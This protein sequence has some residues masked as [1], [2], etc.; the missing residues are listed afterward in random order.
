MEENNFQPQPSVSVVENMMPPQPVRQGGKKSGKWIPVVILLLIAIGVVGWFLLK[1][2][3]E[4]ASTPTPT[5]FVEET[6]P[7]ETVA[8]SPSVSPA[9]DK[10]DV[11]VEILNGT[12]IAGEAALLQKELKALGYTNLSVGNSSQQD[13][14][15]TKVTFSSNL[16]ESVVSEVTAKLKEM[17]KSVDVK[18]TTSNKDAIQIVTGLRKGQ[19]L[20]AATT[21][22][23]ATPKASASPSPSPTTL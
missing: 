15:S 11:K 16:P 20:P 21:A 8:P 6:L 1:G 10:T 13:V 23:S 9:V 22:A 14:T 12:G 4:V 3:S 18:T 5:P 2:G 17:Y 19:T 7:V